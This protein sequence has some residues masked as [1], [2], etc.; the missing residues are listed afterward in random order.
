MELMHHA[1]K[2]PSVPL[3]KA[4]NVADLLGLRKEMAVP[5]SWMAVFLKAYGLVC[6]NNA[7]LR[8]ALIPF[9]W[10]HLYE[11]PLSEGGVVIEREYQGEAVV[12]GAKIRGPENHTLAALHAR[13]RYFKETP[14]EDIA[15]F[16]QVLRIG[17]LPWPLRRLA[18][19]QALNLSG[20]RRAKHLGTFLIS[21]LGNLG[22]EQCHSLT[23]H[24]TYFSFGP[25]GPTG[26]VTLRIFYDHRVMDGRTVARCLNELEDVLHGPIRAEMLEARPE[27]DYPHEEWAQAEEPVPAPQE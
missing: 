8:R 1:R 13:L 21:S 16:R 26:D 23:P 2:V 10:P 18:F 22:V 6:R 5:P 14:V 7:V 17:A 24:T 12:L 3:A 11:H 20:F 15:Y 4:A 19:W 27:P 9:P 25:I